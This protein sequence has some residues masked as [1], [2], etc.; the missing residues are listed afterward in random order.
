VRVRLF[1][2]AALMDV[3]IVRIGRMASIFLLD[4][5]DQA[6]LLVLWLVMGMF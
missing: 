3:R 5:F 6:M 2:V 1:F 4:G